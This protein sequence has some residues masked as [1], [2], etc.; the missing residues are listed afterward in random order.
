MSTF[1]SSGAYATN[2][3]NNAQLYHSSRQ[4]FAIHQH[5]GFIKVKSPKFKIKKLNDQQKQQLTAKL[6]AYASAEKRGA[7]ASIAL[8]LAISAVIFVSSYQFINLLM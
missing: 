4:A 7:L 1:T 2:A 3:A 6:K 5:N 8:T